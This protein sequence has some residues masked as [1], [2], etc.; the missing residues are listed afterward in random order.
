MPMFWFENSS[1][2]IDKTIEGSSVRFKTTYDKRHNLSQRFTD[3]V[4][5]Y[6]QNIFGKGLCDLPI[7][8]LT[9]T[10]QAFAATRTRLC[11]SLD[12]LKLCSS[13]KIFKSQNLH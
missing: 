10:W 9:K 1:Q 5:Q 6:K 13:R 8:E 2:N 3:S 12:S 11:L 7:M 4:E